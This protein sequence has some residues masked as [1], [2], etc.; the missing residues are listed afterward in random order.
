MKG[1][2]TPED[3]PGDD[4]FEPS[5]GGDAQPVEEPTVMVQATGENEELPVTAAMAA[6]DARL[7]GL[8]DRVDELEDRNAALEER[9]DR[10]EAVIYD[11]LE[12]TEHLGAAVAHIDDKAMF[13]G[14]EALSK[15]GMDAYPWGWDA[16]TL[17]FEDRRYE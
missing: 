15:Y 8:A 12:V 17:R 9:A 7:A 4:V 5:S 16:S 14:Q 10:Q 11:L 13:A 3:D 1:F 6:V 2:S